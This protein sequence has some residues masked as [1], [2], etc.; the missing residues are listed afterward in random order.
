M[1]EIEKLFISSEPELELIRFQN[2]TATFQLCDID[3]Y[4]IGKLVFEEVLSMC[5]S[6]QSYDKI[7][8]LNA[9]EVSKTG[10]L[11]IIPDEYVLIVFNP[12]KN[13]F[14]EELL[15]NC[16][17]NLVAFIVCKVFRFEEETNAGRG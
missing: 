3:G 15:P 7:S 16:N 11:K 12:V 2:F 17:G 6:W 5:I 13:G 10:M 4:R 8:I 9:N 1:K 14:E